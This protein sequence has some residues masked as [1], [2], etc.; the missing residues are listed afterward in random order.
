MSE[1]VIE[2]VC[3][4]YGKKTV[5]ENVSLTLEKGRC[6]GI[7]GRNSSG[8]STLINMIMQRTPCDK[9]K[10]TLDGKN[11]AGNDI[12]M[13]RLFGMSDN[14][15]YPSEF[16]LKTILKITAS[17]FYGFDPA[18]AKALAEKCGLNLNS[19]VGK[20]STGHCTAFKVILA[21]ASNADYIFLDEPVLGV[22]TTIRELIYTE[23]AEKIAEERSCFGITTHLIE[24]ISGLLEYVSIL[25]R[26]G[27]IL[28]DTIENI[29]GKYI[30]VSGKT[31]DVNRFAQDKKL[32]G[33]ESI[34]L[35]CRAVIQT[36]GESY[37]IPEGLSA[38]A[39]GLQELFSFLTEE[40]GDEA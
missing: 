12:A 11:I 30:T 40:D 16:K 37:E 17:M 13:S 33:V 19:R 25:H 38:G 2:N 28:S 27:F 15:F 8:K 35:F 10:I 26:G 36:D 5:L 7:L 24:E 1:L 22:D 23:L 31:D 32:I 9:G 34:G 39:V 6:Y 29:I 20:L 18:Y 21:L 3:K 14:A 4:K